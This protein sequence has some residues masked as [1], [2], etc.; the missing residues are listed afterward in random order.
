MDRLPELAANLVRLKVDVILAAGGDPWIRA[1]K[2]ATKTIP[3]IVT[4]QAPI[5]SR[6][7]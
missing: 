4:G 2:K 1:A 5:L 3:I 6:Q 7:A